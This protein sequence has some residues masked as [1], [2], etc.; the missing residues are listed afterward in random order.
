MCIL[1][2]A[3][4]CFSQWNISLW[5]EMSVFGNNFYQ[6][7]FLSSHCFHAM[8]SYFVLYLRCFYIKYTYLFHNNPLAGGFISIWKETVLKM[9][10]LFIYLSYTL[11]PL[12]GTFHVI[13]TPP[14]Y[15]IRYIQCIKNTFP[16]FGVRFPHQNKHKRKHINICPQTT[17]FLS[18]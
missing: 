17:S 6:M 11:L 1:F 16:N 9:V 3:N 8:M 18:Y 12:T 7:Q 15:S 13:I 10:Y 14:L 4:G 2:V 5:K